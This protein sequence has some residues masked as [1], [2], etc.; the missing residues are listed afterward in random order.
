[1]RMDK[2]IV[3][4]SECSYCHNWRPF[5]GGGWGEWEGP[6][7]YI[8]LQNLKF[9]WAS[10]GIFARNNINVIYVCKFILLHGKMKSAMYVGWLC[11]CVCVCLCICVSSKNCQNLSAR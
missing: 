2:I 9:T 11:G 8:H 5:G 3:V 10:P 1:M 6:P 4:S 7:E